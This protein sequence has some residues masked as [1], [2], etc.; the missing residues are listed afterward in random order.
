MR[1]RE[2]LLEGKAPDEILKVIHAEFPGSKATR[3]DVS[4]NKGRLRRDGLLEGG[5]PPL[6]AG[7]KSTR[8]VI[9]D[10]FEGMQLKHQNVIGKLKNSV[11]HPQPTRSTAAQV[12]AIIDIKPEKPTGKFVKQVPPPFKVKLSDGLAAKLNQRKQK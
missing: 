6:V 12:K 2:M 9:D 8:K 7:S 3:S 1:I 10:A 5:V 11:K 4:W